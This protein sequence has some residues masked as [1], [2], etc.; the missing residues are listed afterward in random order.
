MGS[1]GDAFEGQDDG[2]A[3]APIWGANLRAGRGRYCPDCGVELEAGHARCRP[4]FVRDQDAMRNLSER[5]WFERN[6][7]GFRPARIFPGESPGLGERVDE[8][9]W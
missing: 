7:P 2:Q 5:A 1:I 9:R 4:C 3:A 6:C 8:E